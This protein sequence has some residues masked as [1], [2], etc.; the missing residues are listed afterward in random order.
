MRS[1]R[2]TDIPV[3][4][5]YRALP[6]VT[7]FQSWTTY[8]LEDAKRL[9]AELAAT[10][11]GK[12]G[13]W[14]QIAIADTRDDAL[15][16]DCALHFLEDERQ[17]EIGF[18]VAP[19]HQ[20][21]GLAKEALSLLLEHVFKVMHKHRAVAITDAQND[22]AKKLLRGLGFRQEGHFLQNLWFKGRWGD[23]CLFA[24]LASEWQ[25]RQQGPGQD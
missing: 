20:G 24:C 15:L 3:F 13:T 4:A 7:R 19:E 22:P 14:F 21:K 25:A 6:A 23:E 2:E 16:G 11:F 12:P 9:Y 18:T 10:P 1:F 8:S 17:V 5:A